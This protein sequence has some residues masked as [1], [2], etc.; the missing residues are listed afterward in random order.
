M[1]KVNIFFAEG[2]E[3]VEALTVVDILRRAG[4]VNCPKRETLAIDVKTEKKGKIENTG[5]LPAGKV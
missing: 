1:K 2:F 4:I 3:E 5:L